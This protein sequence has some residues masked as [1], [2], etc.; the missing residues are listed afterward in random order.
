[1]ELTIEEAVQRVKAEIIAPDWRLNPR[2]IEAL[3]EALACLKNRFRDRRSLKAIL[4][5]AGNVLLYIKAHGDHSPPDSIDFLKEAMADVVNLYEEA[6]DP[7]QEEQVVKKVFTHFQGLKEKIK[8]HQKQGPSGRRPNGPDGQAQTERPAPGEVP[9]GAGGERQMSREPAVQAD[10]AGQPR[11][12]SEAK[13]FLAE[14]NHTLERAAEVGA[15]LE[16]LLTAAATFRDGLLPGSPAAALPAPDG[17]DPDPTA[18]GVDSGPGSKNCPP[19][20]LREV[21]VGDR[22]VGFPEE[23]VAMIRPLSA[24][25]KEK[26]LKEGLVPLRDFHRLF[27]R[28]ARR[29]E[30]SLATLPAR[31]LKKLVLPVI[32]LRAVGMPELPDPRADTLLVLSYGHWHG[33]VLC[34][35]AEEEPRVMTGFRKAA[36]G[37]IAG[38]GAIEDGGELPVANVADLLRREGFLAIN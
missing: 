7:E 24:A 34:S 31:K 10:A 27:S 32:F 17:A 12:N 21:V 26:Y 11:P 23:N 4:T 37:D 14:L 20:P 5:M 2:R 9:A 16:E 18:V 35:G 28:L 22:S 8:T 15:A 33:V 36:N 29:F 13:R 30:G 3:G 19:T 25:A 38:V 6:Y 1:M